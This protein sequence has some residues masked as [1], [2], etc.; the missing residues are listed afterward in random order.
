NFR[1]VLVHKAGG[2]GEGAFGL[3][4]FNESDGAGD[5]IADINGAYIV[6][7]HF[8][9][10]KAYH[11]TDV[12]DHAA[13]EQAGDYTPAKPAIFDEGFIYMVRVVVPGDAAKQGYISLCEGAPEGEG[14][15]YLYGCK[16]G[17]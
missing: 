9:G 4:L 6:E 16:G 15:P 8:C 3:V 17:S 5:R 2:G 11:A 10:E 7:M 14:L 12:G 13:G 1:P